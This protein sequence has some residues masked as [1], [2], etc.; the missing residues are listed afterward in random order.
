MDPRETRQNLNKSGDAFQSDGI[1][2]MAR[3]EIATTRHRMDGTLS[4][5]AERL[6]PRHL[7]DEAIGW[8]RSSPEE[9][10]ALENTAKRMGKNIIH[11]IEDHPLPALMI[12]GAAALYFVERRREQNP[13]AYSQDGYLPEES[14]WTEEESPPYGGA[15]TWSGEGAGETGFA[16]IPAA[17][18]PQGSTAGRV[19]EGLHEVREKAAE[20]R[21]RA[22]ASVTR[23]RRKLRRAGAHWQER[24]AETTHRIRTRTR[25]A[26]ESGRD[27]FEGV[28]DDHPLGAGLASLAFG[29]L[30]GLVTPSTRREEELLGETSRRV[31]EQSREV[32]HDALRKG[33]A[34]ASAASD[35]AAHEAEAQELTPP[36]IAE[37]IGAVAESAVHA[38][39][40]KSSTS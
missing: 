38:G 29:L 32:V 2:R 12:G 25:E 26:Y 23:G 17:T 13:D 11:W 40:E 37:K 22:R 7:L 4:Q 9:V 33:R 18:K 1:G 34:M 19:K 15:A 31:K 35:A 3:A 20:L 6:R 10:E 21:E 16:D 36:Q 14:E 24:Q 28:V 5:I 8:A 30:V 27:R 39:M